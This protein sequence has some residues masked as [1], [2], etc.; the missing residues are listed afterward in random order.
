MEKEKMIIEFLKCNENISINK[1]EKEL[2]MANRTIRT[3]GSRGIPEKYIEGIEDYLKPFGYDPDM[4][5][6]VKEEI[7]EDN[8]KEAV[9]KKIWN[10][11]WILGYNDKIYRYRD[12]E[13]LMRR[14][15][16]ED[17]SPEKDDKGREIDKK[18]QPQ[19]GTLHDDE[20]GKFYIARNGIKVYVDYKHKKHMKKGE[21]RKVIK[22]KVEEI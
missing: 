18:W 11:G 17:Y 22:V 10:E 20:I 6:L 8:L 12:E 4:V 15:V 19:D 3:D 16:P 2:G 7:K 1:M 21:I 13:G 9:V 14:L 5:S